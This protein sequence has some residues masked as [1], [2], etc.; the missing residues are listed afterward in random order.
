TAARCVVL[1]TTRWGGLGPKA[2][3]DTRRMTWTVAVA[4]VVPEDAVTCVAPA[5]TAVSTPFASIVATAGLDELHATGTLASGV[6]FASTT[7]AGRVASVP[8]YIRAGAWILTPPAV[9]ATRSVF[10][11][12]S[13]DTVTSA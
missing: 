5:A 1:A 12:P 2:I 3:V 7:L 4:F 9:T 11:I 10:V 6:F 13:T 8:A